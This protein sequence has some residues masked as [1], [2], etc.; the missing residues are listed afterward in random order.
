[1]AARSCTTSAHGLTVDCGGVALRVYEHGHREAPPLVL[2]HGIQDFALSLGPIAEPFAD[3]YRVIAFDLRGHGDS[4]KPGAYTFSHYLADL[5]GLL[6][7]LELERPLLAGHSL[8]GQIVTHYAGVFP[9]VPRAVVSIEGL[10]PPF[11]GM[12]MPGEARRARTRAGARCLY[13]PEP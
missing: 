12:D 7:Q 2:V 13:P 10:G 6:Q 1:M 9:E 3:R 4:D 5:H 11:R 8:G